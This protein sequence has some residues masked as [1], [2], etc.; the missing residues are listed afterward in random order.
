MNYKK[1]Y[2]NIIN[3]GR[4]RK[5]DKY[6]ERHHI[7]PLSCN[8]T[9]DPLNLVY[10]TTREHFICHRLLVKM[11]KDEIIFKKKMI[12]A[13]WWMCKTRANM[14]KISSR[15]YA[16]V[17]YQFIKNNP[18]KCEIR[19]QQFR[20]NHKLGLYQYNYET[21][22]K[23]LSHT[24]SQLST[25]QMT[26]RMLKSSGTCDHV[27]RGIAIRKGKGSQLS[28]QY[29]D[30]SCISFWSYD[31][32]KEITGYNYSQLCYRIKA[33]NGVLLNGNRVSYI[34]RY[35]GNDRN[36]R[37]AHEKNNNISVIT[38]GTQGCI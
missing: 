25:E 28:M 7:I 37:R 36:A 35:I 12:Y 4:D 31:N 38:I 24:L 20:E 11:Y 18:N 34:T 22:G 33:H 10:L 26:E 21:V 32:V 3:N 14:C 17:R 19:K 8:G 15:T 2:Y 6:S 1:L 16:H 9:N 13:L 27:A 23:T 5:K 30:N 29:I